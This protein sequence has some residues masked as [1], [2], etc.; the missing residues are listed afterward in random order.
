MGATK[1]HSVGRDLGVHPCNSLFSGFRG[2]LVLSPVLKEVAQVV[3]S[4][5]A[6]G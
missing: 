3:F 5:E 2:I 1:L 6:N 4:H